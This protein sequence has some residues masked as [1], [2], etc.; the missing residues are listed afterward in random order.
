MKSIKGLIKI[1]QSENNKKKSGIKK[2]NIK[3]NFLQNS[4]GIYW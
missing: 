4:L 2:P 3:I 1:I